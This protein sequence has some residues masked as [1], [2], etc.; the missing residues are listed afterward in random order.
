MIDHRSYQVALRAKA[1][2]LSVVTTGSISLSATAT[3]YAR[4]SGSFLA[5]GF[6]RGME[7][8]PSGFASNPVDV[9]TDVS[10]L[11]ITT[12]NARTVEGAAGSR[13]LA[14]GLPSARAWENKKPVQD[15]PIAGI[16]FVREQYI[17]G[18]PALQVTLGQFGDLE[19]LPQYALHIHVPA[20]CGFEAP[21][22]YA[23]AVMRLFTPRTAIPVGSD[24]LRVSDR[25]PFRGTLTQS[26]PGFA[27]VPIT[28][29]LWIRTPNSI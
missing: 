27:V 26:S 7:L 28:A 25:G 12:K 13:T 20:D 8:T 4:A 24:V 3:G 10:A 2:T 19:L 5:D 22:A 6:A 1:L 15:P 9:I 16:P 17:P 23:D 18:P 21:S 11:S 29:P 14:V